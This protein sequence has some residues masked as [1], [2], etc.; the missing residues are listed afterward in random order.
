MLD[1]GLFGGSGDGGEGEDTSSAQSPS[2]AV[3][4]YEIGLADD[5]ESFTFTTNGLL[6][7]PTQMTSTC[8]CS[9]NLYNVFVAHLRLHVLRSDVFDASKRAWEPLFRFTNSGW[10]Y[11]YPNVWPAVR[12]WLRWPSIR[13]TT[14]G[15]KTVFIRK[16]VRADRAKKVFSYLNL[17]GENPTSH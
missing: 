15:G 17:H 6:D 16:K 2:L 4:P 13:V 9:D 3:R 11:L 12:R 8:I 1:T 5:E 14:F 7:G 10:I